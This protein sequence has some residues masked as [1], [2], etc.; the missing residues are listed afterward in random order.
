M[1]KEAFKTDAE[2]GE[3]INIAGLG[4]VPHNP[5]GKALIKFKKLQSMG[6]GLH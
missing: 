1:G 4:M 5:A 6:M 3:M 2:W